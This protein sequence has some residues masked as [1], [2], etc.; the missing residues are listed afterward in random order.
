MEDTAAVAVEVV[1]QA[2][3]WLTAQQ[4]ILM[5]EAQAVQAVAVPQAVKAATA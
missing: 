5:T 3:E 4:D 1:P 2:A